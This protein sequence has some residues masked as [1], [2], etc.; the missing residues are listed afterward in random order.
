M[1]HI[2]YDDNLVAEVRAQVPCLAKARRDYARRV[3]CIDG[4]C[5]RAIADVCYGSPMAYLEAAPDAVLSIGWYY[6]A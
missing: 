5:W 1:G 6:V 3:T 2:E 4:D